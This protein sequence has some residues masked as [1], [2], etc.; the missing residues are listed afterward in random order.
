MNDWVSAENTALLTDLYE[1]TMAAAY[2]AQGR[3]ERV[4]FELFVRSLPE[5]RNFLVACGLEQALDYLESLHFGHDGLEYLRSLGRF[6]DDFLDMLATLRFTGDVWAVPE[7]E[8]VF[9]GEPLL[10]LSAPLIEGQLVETFLL[11]TILFQTMVASKAVRVAIAC[12]PDRPFSDFSARRDHGPDAALKAAR[13]AYVGGAS[14]TSNVL[15]GQRFGIPLTGTMAH[16]YVMAFEQEIDAF[17]CFSRA[18]PDDAVLLLDTYDTVQAA[19]RVVEL[20]PELRAEGVHLAGVRIDSGDLADLAKQVRAIFDAGG[21][22]DVPILV[23]GDLDEHRIVELTEKGAPVAGFGVGTRLGTSADAP[24]LGGVYKLVVDV[25]GPRMKTSPGKTTLPGCKQIYR[26]TEAGVARRDVLSL[27]DEMSE[28]RPLL[29][30]VMDDGV[31][32]DPPEP[33][34]E[35]RERARASVAALPEALR[36]L[37]RRE[38]YPVD[39][40][41]GLR[42]LVVDV[43]AR[44]G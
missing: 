8:V 35:I 22:A 5:E 14:S 30:R 23:S 4:T 36:R 31:R 27:S 12:G 25:H 7:G 28:G 29:R 9:P 24:Y 19:K 32:G 18:F 6:D 34:G 39:L 42:K 2:H 3:N 15:A 1:L 44:S 40:S 37:D 26:V 21:L 43:E 41:D 16:A 33:L 38:P 20:A 11:S 13:A 10:S 17:R